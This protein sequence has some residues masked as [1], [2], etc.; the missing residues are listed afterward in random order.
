MSAHF[1]VPTRHGSISLVK[2]GEAIVVFCGGD[3]V[4]VSGGL[5]KAVAAT[6]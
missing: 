2:A 6:K 4:A 3:A 1:G 5:P